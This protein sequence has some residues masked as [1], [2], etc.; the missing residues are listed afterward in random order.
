MFGAKLVVSCLLQK[1]LVWKLLKRTCHPP[2]FCII[3]QMCQWSYTEC[4]QTHEGKTTTDVLPY[5][6]GL[7]CF[8]QTD[9]RTVL[10]NTVL[11]QSAESCNGAVQYTPENV[12]HLNN[13]LSLS[14]MT[15]FDYIDSSQMIKLCW[16]FSVCTDPYKW[17][18]SR[19][20]HT[21]LWIYQR[22]VCKKYFL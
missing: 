12:Y 3:P 2:H 19:Y 10:F 14:Q 9:Y 21:D 20:C 15:K 11:V 17:L 8:I 1:R 22:L 16:S 4:L 6:N 18:D 13:M 5:W 7:F